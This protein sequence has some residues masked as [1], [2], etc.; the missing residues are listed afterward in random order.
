MV[1]FDVPGMDG[2]K[3]GLIS[4][5]IPLYNVQDYVGR[6]IASV[7]AQTYKNLEIILVDDGSTDLSGSICDE[8]AA[9]DSRI[10]VIHKQNGGVASA[11]NTGL[12]AAKGEYITFVDSDDYIEAQMYEDMLGA[13][14]KN[15]ADLAVC[16]YKAVDQNGIRDT[17]TE[18]IT[19]FQGREAL[20]VFVAEDER[21]NIQNAVWNKLYK[22]EL[23]E[24]LGFEDGRIFEDIIYAA[25]L[26]ARSKKCVYLNHAYYEYTLD[27][28]AS[29]MNSK[30]IQNILTDQVEAYTEKGEFLKEIGEEKLYRIHQFFFYK[31][32]LLHYI[33]VY[34]QKPEDYRESL[35]K[36]QE[37]IGRTI[38]WEVFEGQPKGDFVRMKLFAASPVLYI[39][40]MNV[41]EKYIIPWKQR[42]NERAEEEKL[43]VIR[44]SGGLGNQMFQYALYLQL[45]K[46]GKNVKIDDVTEYDREGVRPIHLPIFGISY[47]TPSK[48]EMIR[49]TDARMDLFSRIRRKLTGRKTAEYPEISMRFDPQV[50]NLDR[51]YLTG[52]WQTAKYFAGAETEVREAFSFHNLKLSDNMQKY[53][54]KIENTNAIA[55]H[56]RR[57]DYLQV[58]EVY[59]GICTEEY[60]ENALQK[61]EEMEPDCHFFVF[62]NDPEWVKTRFTQENM[63]IVEGNDENAGYVDMYLMSRCRHFIIANSSFSW[64]AAWLGAYACKKVIAPETWF[65]GMDCADIYEGLSEEMIWLK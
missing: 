47:P 62:S 61:F 50:L 24:N 48:E 46:L 3:S 22:R 55:V 2:G 14:L 20:E 38:Q 12:H 11:R 10:R 59:C 53:K 37:V 1:H 51:A 41:N 17:S 58:P 63:T 28:N 52:V 36:L 25:K 44:L 29:I 65:H 42:R 27:R 19:V 45:K 5:I 16:N 6:A 60:Y 4:V 43:V 35:K 13:L 32:M 54:E 57:G 26:I 39:A 64:W 7:C 34:R 40:F 31:R 49:L 23:T 9:K 21:Y 56:I 30:K 33:D 18:D 15:Q 8:W